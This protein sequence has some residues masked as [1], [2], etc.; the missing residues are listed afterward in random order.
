MNK[1]IVFALGAAA[2]IAAGILLA[3]KSGM[4]TISDVKGAATDVYGKGKSY[5]QKGAQKFQSTVFSARPAISQGAE[6]L[7]SKIEVA[8]QIIADQV[9]KNASE[10]KQAIADNAAIAAEIIEE[11]KA[12]LE[13]RIADFASDSESS[14]DDGE[15]DDDVSIGEAVDRV[16]N[17]LAS[18]KAAID[19]KLEKAFEGIRAAAADA[20]D[21]IAEAV[22]EVAEG[23]AVESEA[24]G[25]V[26]EAAD[27]A[28][29]PA[30]ELPPFNPDDINPDI[31]AAVESRF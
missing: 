25:E 7:Q 16:L 24:V 22:A 13:D 4:E 5:A 27:A 10:A 6:Q 1:G 15:D 17:T 11:K 20:G 19:G 9:A 31:R 2:G 8:R 3:P 28:E 12:E 29:E 21:Q 23:I 30:S 26:A 18:A 14:D